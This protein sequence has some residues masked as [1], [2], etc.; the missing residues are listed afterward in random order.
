MVL[1]C[2]VYEF[3]SINKYAQQNLDNKM[4]CGKQMCKKVPHEQ[5]SQR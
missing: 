1:K 5:T 4:L 2:K 3:P